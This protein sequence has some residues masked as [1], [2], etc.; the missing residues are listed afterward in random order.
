MLG[1][2]MGCRIVRNSW[3]KSW[4]MEGYFYLKSGENACA[5]NTGVTTS[6]IKKRQ[7]DTAV[8]MA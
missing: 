6:I 7:T 4:G 1:A 3:G 8:A 5:V 2:L